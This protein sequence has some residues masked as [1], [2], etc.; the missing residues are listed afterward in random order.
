MGSQ[1]YHTQLYSPYPTQH[2]GY[3][4]GL[5]PG[6]ELVSGSVKENGGFIIRRRSYGR[7][8]GGKVFIPSDSHTGHGSRTLPET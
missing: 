2:L 5:R 8:H 6:Y 1:T 7:S 4:V 3:G